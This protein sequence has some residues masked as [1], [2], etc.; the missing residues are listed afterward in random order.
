MVYAV[1]KTRFRAT[2]HWPQC[3]I[4][5]V[6]FL[7][8]E[9]HHEFNVCVQIQQFHN[10]RDVEYLSFQSYL[11]TQIQKM[12][13]ELKKFRSCE[14]MASYLFKQIRKSY[15]NRL[16]KVEVNEDNYYGAQVE[17]NDLI[18]LSWLAGIIDGEG[19]IYLI[20]KTY[21]P[22]IMIGN[23]NKRIIA[24]IYNIIKSNNIKQNK[25]FIEKS[26]PKRIL[27]KPFYRICITGINNIYQVLNLITPYL[28]GKREQADIL[29]KYC[30]YRMEKQKNK[31][32]QGN[33][34]KYYK[35]LALD[36]KSIATLKKLQ[37]LNCSKEA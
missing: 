36:K 22:V 9:H 20:N 13:A 31:R 14:H 27:K 18:E 23:Y 24:K 21:Q 25:I 5:S 28:V 17:Q 37:L 26:T 3:N 12:L 2:H 16:L 7:K 6:N 34:G 29:K 4:K 32:G 33:R 35:N 11:D 10:E 30:E 8:N 15:P 19:S 1:I